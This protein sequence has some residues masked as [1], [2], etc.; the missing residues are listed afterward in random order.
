MKKKTFSKAIGSFP[1]ASKEADWS[2]SL[3]RGRVPGPRMDEHR[4][5]AP[6]F[7]VGT[8]AIHSGTYLD[9]VTGAVGTPVFQTST[10]HF[11]DHTYE[12]FAQGTIRDTPIYT[13]YGNP[14]LWSVQEKMAALEKAESSLICASGMAA[15]TTTLLA[16]T[17]NGGHIISSRDVYG[18]TYNLLREDMHQFGRE[19]SF[20]ASTSIEAIR[21][22]IRENTQVLFFETLTNPLLKGLPLQEIGELA[23]EY[24]LLFI[25]DNTFLTPYHLAPISFGAHLVVHS[26]TKYLNGHSDLVAGVVSGSRKYVD[27]VWAQMLKFGGSINPLSAFLLERGIKT[28]GVRMQKHAENANAIS[29]YLNAHSKVRKVH[30]PSV[31]DYEYPWVRAYCQNGFSG[32][33]SFELKGGDQA[34]LTFLEHLRIPVVATS[35]GGVESL[36]SLPFNTSHSFLTE[37]QKA[38]VGIYPGLVRLSVGIEEIE[39]LV[40]DLEQALEKI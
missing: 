1:E 20:V 13:R 3:K 12:S 30:Y 39:D 40:V 6:E 31:D 18:G 5:L 21:A 33:V 15:I 2:N 35:L 17:N 22:S 4:M 8:H 37:R 24:N 26:C 28:L 27:R 7:G 16:L 32:M 36:I 29:G 19:V 23:R 38:D 10:F 14:S 34:A 25:V 11:S 9:P